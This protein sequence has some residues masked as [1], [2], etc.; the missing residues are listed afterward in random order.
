[1]KK[2]ASLHEDLAELLISVLDPLEIAAIAMWSPEDWQAL[3]KYMVHMLRHVSSQGGIQPLSWDVNQTLRDDAEKKK[4]RQKLN[5]SD[6]AIE[7]FRFFGIVPDKSLFVDVPDIYADGGVDGTVSFSLPA[8]VSGYV[9][10]PA[11]VILSADDESDI[12]TW[13]Y[14]NCDFNDIIGGVHWDFDSSYVEPNRRNISVDEDSFEESGNGIDFS[15]DID[16]DDLTMKALDEY[17]IDYD[18]WMNYD[19]EAQPDDEE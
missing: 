9:R 2:R 19:P 12:Q 16:F 7:K 8:I 1:M 13:V 10:V 17:G 18:E 3:G 5:N 4:I 11:H 15:G 14:N 6:T